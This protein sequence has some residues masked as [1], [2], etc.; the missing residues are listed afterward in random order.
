VGLVKEEEVIVDTVALSAFRFTK[1]LVSSDLR[2]LLNDTEVS[3]S[4]LILDLLNEKFVVQ[5]N[6]L[7]SVDVKY[8]NLDTFAVR[9]AISDVLKLEWIELKN[10]SYN[11]STDVKFDF[12]TLTG[13]ETLS[14]FQDPELIEAIKIN[15]S[16]FNETQFTI[17]GRKDYLKIFRQL[18]TTLLDTSGRDVTPAVVELCY[19]KDDLSLFLPLEKTQLIAKLASIRTFGVEPPLI[20]DPTIVFLDLDFSVVLQ[21]TSGNAVNAVNAVIDPYQK[22][23]NE[24][25][26]FQQVEENIEDNDFV[27]I[28]RVSIDA[29]TWLANT[30]YLRGKHVT[31]PSPNGFIYEMIDIA[32]FSGSTTPAFDCTEGEITNDNG[33]MW[34]ASDKGLCDDPPDWMPSTR[35]F[36][37]DVVKDA[38]CPTSI[39]TA[40]SFINRSNSSQ[41]VQKVQFSTVPTSGTWRIEFN[42]EETGDLAYNANALA[43]Q[44]AL[45]GLTNL[46]GVIVTGSHTSEFL[47]TFAGADSNTPQPPMTFNNPGVNEVQCLQFSDTPD[48]GNFTVEFQ[49]QVTGALPFSTTASQ[50]QAALEL[51]SSIGVGN[52][53][54]TGNYSSNFNITFVGALQK[55]N[56]P[57]ITNPFNSLVVGATVIETVVPITEGAAPVVGVN[58][59]QKLA[60]S[61]VPDSGQF[62]I[63]FDSSTT[64]LLQYNASAA[65]V[66]TALEALS[67][68]G[69]G[70]VVVTGNFTAGFSVAFQGAL[71][72]D[73]LVSMTIP[74]N[75]LL[76]SQ[77]VTPTVTTP[78]NG[79][80]GFNEVQQIKF[81]FVPDAGNWKL[82]FTYGGQAE[83][84]D[85]TI[86]GDS[87]GDLAGKYWFFNTVAQNYYVWY[88]VDGSATDPGPIVGRVGIPVVIATN[89]NATT[90]KA[91]TLA[92]IIAAA[93]A[94][95]T[96]TSQYGSRIRLTNVTQGVVPD[97][98][99]QTSGFTVVVVNQG[100]NPTHET[101]MLSFSSTASFIEQEL[102]ALP[103]I[104]A[105]NVEVSGDFVSGFLITFR[106]ALGNLNVNP[107]VV[108]N[109]TL[110]KN[111]I[112]NIAV[113]TTTPGVVPVAGINEVQKINFNTP[114]DSGTWELKYNLEVTS[115]LGFAATA[116]DVQNALN[117]LT[118]L[119]A[120]TV[121]GNFSLGFTVTFAGADGSQDQPLLIVQNSTLFSA[122]TP[123]TV[124]PCLVTEG[125]FPAQNLKNISLVAVAVTTL[126][127][128]DAVNPEPAWFTNVIV[129]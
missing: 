108:L 71:A 2:V 50:L 56:L 57:A 105:N 40:T 94:N 85:V 34:I 74:S 106:N 52:V 47:M 121:T 38:S 76:K 60:F 91:A 117:A 51:L 7:G 6:A 61:L 111:Q 39:F 64:S 36:I 1:N 122:S 53:L 55:Q 23:L 96:A 90:V 67:T 11:A 102:K 93:S 32:Y 115:S 5:S 97:G 86:N 116:L 80:G 125:K 99:G 95:V 18:D 4:E 54:V 82:S 22:V 41:E 113:Q 69:V 19:V 98:T 123:V 27:K 110:I 16:I 120:V 104:G 10:I 44:N 88:N 70:N 45:N 119:S 103:N 81:D 127:L 75:S 49:S 78:Q 79:G 35:Y 73:D 84:T 28:A 128:S 30:N 37:G 124:T 9:Y 15:A 59:V 20:A 63:D 31:P 87:S 58:E 48:G 33:I 118:G 24:F 17:R 14:I 3:I 42:G 77:V 83:V 129:C 107:V 12:G 66:Q 62:A 101:N 92:A 13:V 72:A 109:N 112:V 8:L 114:P 126:T 46:S 89:D 68:I 100:I 43:V 26:D 65:Q 25:V 21:S 29:P